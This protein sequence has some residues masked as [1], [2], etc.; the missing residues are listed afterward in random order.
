[1]ADYEYLPVSSGSG[2]A[3]KMNIQT[4]RTAGA[5]VIDVD[6]V[7]NVPTEFIG[8]WG[9]LGSDGLITLASKRDFKGRVSGADIIIDAMC[10]GNTDNGNTVG[11]VIL[12]KPNTFWSNLVATFIKNATGFDT[13]EAVTFGSINGN[14]GLTITSGAVSLPNN[15]LLKAALEKPHYGKIY[16]ATQFT[17]QVISNSE[18]RISFNTLE[19]ESVGITAGGLGGAAYLQVNRAGLYDVTIQ[20]NSSDGATSGSVIVWLAITNEAGVLINRF[21]HYDRT[22]AISQGQTYGHKVYLPLGYRIYVNCYS[23]DAN[24]RLGYGGTNDTF[25]QKTFGPYLAVTEIR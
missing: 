25:N 23:G 3:A 20:I 24:F 13:P 17:G 7:T 5:T 8:T 6:S 18:A 19:A 16:F 14:N 11:Q 21:R 12:V 4:D 1:M 9:T 2:D 22:I 10:P 15:S